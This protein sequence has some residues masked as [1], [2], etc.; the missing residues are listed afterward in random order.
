V[1]RYID[2]LSG[3]GKVF[4]VSAGNQGDNK[5]H[6]SATVTGGSREITFKVAGYSAQ[7]GPANDLIFLDGWYEGTGQV[8]ITIIS[9]SD[10]SYGP[11]TDG[12]YRE[13]NTQDGHILI[14]NGFFENGPYYE[15]GVNPFNYDKEILILISDEGTSS[16]P[17]EGTWTIRM[18][19]NAGGDVHFWLADASMEVEFDI[20]LDMDMTLSMPGTARSAITVGAYTTRDTWKDMDGNNLTIDTQGTI[21]IGDI[22]AFSGA[23]PTR[24]DRVKPEITAPG[25][26]IASTYSID[27]PAGSASSI[28]LSPSPSYPNAFIMPDSLHGLSLGTSMAAPFVTG[29]CALLLEKYPDADAAKIKQL[30]TYTAKAPSFSGNSNQWGFGK[31]DAYRAVIT[32]INTLPDSTDTT[33]QSR[34]E[35]GHPTPNPCSGGTKIKYTLPQ[36]ANT[37]QTVT[38]KIY[39]R[40]GQMVRRISRISSPGVEDI[41]FW[42]CR[43]RKGRLVANGVYFLEFRS[44]SFKKIQKVTVIYY[45]Q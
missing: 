18:S 42:D 32:D 8:S 2:T 17:A 15:P 29:V 14:L 24:D 7:F 19:G 44:G 22:A 20:G 11:L 38:L 6:A 21:R 13:W 9:P 30:L 28:F 33:S 41:L 35:V 3:N 1:E 10:N 31:L 36:D 45:P 16:P 40:I 34:Y 43:D 39:N 4:I 37:Q 12:N 26:I 5:Y 25:Q 27:A 23:G